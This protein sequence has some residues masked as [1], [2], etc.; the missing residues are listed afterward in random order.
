VRCD[1]LLAFDD[2]I[3]NNGT[4]YTSD[5]QFDTRLGQFDQV[6]LVCTLTNVPAAVGTN[7]AKV[8]VYLTHSG[9]R[10]TFIPK[11][12]T[13]GPPPT[14][15]E[16]SITWTAKPASGLV[17]WGS[18]PNTLVSATP[19][20]RYVRINL[21]MTHSSGPVRARVY[22]TLRDQATSAAEER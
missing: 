7:T 2:F 1:H 18:D 6:A 14:N 17:G 5:F 8:L 4:P 21:Y 16:V 19:S 11:N 3:P 15:P 12:G 13:G 9:D 10:E 20:L 22:A